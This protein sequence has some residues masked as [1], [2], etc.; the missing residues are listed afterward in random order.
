MFEYDGH[1]LLYVNVSESK[2]VTPKL[3]E[4]R[5]VWFCHLPYLF[6]RMRDAVE[7]CNFKSLQ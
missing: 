7:F 6:P 1:F 4:F 2:E 3:S 5:F